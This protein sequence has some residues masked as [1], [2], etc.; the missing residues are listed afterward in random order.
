MWGLNMVERRTARAMHGRR[1][2]RKPGRVVGF[3]KP[4]IG[5]RRLGRN[6]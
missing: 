4:W 2:V 1:R 5:W 3:G 6:S